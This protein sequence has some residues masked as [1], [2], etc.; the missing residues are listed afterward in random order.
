MTKV[1]CSF[2]KGGE[3]TK[4]SENTGSERFAG[5]CVCRTVGA[6]GNLKTTY[7]DYMIMEPIDGE[8]ELKRVP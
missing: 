7:G 5:E 4:N 8:T 2:D 3:D 1:V 6:M